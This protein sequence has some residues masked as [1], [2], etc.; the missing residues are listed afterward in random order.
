[1]QVPAAHALKPEDVLGEYWKDP[2]FGSAAA[3]ETV[4]IEILHKLIWP[5]AFEVPVGKNIRFV[6]TN[7]TE[8]VH[9]LALAEDPEALL[10]DPQF[11]QLRDEDVFHAS[12]APVRSEGHVHAGGNVDDPQ[13]IV[14]T[15][16]RN[17]S[18]T[19]RPGEF[20]ELIVRFD[21]ARQLHLFCTLEEHRFEGFAS[22]FSIVEDASR[23][24]DFR[25][26]R[27]E[28]IEY[29]NDVRRNP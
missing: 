15:M 16:D 7:K 10:N 1:M 24:N 29:R 2:L 9:S 3:E 26:E 8:V 17:P 14:L 22:S 20:K 12:Q 25:I 5:K 27:L 19:V 6:V 28:R 4:Q 11:V 23:A 21:S 13:P 18:V